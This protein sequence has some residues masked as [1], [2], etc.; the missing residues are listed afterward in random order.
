MFCAMF[1][2]P[3]CDD[4]DTYAEMRSRERKQI[5]SFLENGCEVWDGDSTVQLLKVRKINVISEEQ[6]Y[7][8]DSTTSVAKN[9]YVLFKST[10]IYM[11]IV[12]K[13]TGSI[14]AEGEGKPVVMRYYE[15][16]IAGDSLQTTNQTIAYE[17]FP[18]KMDVRNTLGVISGSFTEGVMMSYYGSAAVPSGWLLPLKFIKLGRQNS[19]DAE[20]ALVRL[21]VPS[22]EGQLDA[23]GNVY[24]CFY[25]ISYMAGRG[26]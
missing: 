6:F 21:I 3:S 12:R 2:L 14:L 25:E 19:P 18:D 13:G 4:D 23:S 22:T 8:N 17:P 15:F 24:P 7:A 11:Q 26:N 1:C 5:A 16:N 9:E 10:G 20:I